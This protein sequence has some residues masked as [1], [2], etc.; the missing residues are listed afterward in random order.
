MTANGLPILWQL[1][2]SH[3]NEKARWALD[4][5]RIPH[6]RRALVPGLHLVVARSLTDGAIETTPVLTLDGRS[7]GDSTAIIAALEERWPQPPLYP[8]DPAERR[9]ALEL[10]EYFDEELGP[11][12]RRALYHELLT[13][14]ELV[15]P[16]MVRGQRRFIQLLFRLA[17][18]ILASG[19]PPALQRQRDRGARQP[20]AI[21]G[22]DGADRARARSQRLSGRRPVHRR[23]PDGRVAALPGGAS[24]RSSRIR[25]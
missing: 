6:V 16:L 5:K 13:R 9:R 1:E 4:F 19:D 22:R 3:Y 15:V 17:F 10:E 23:R 25:Q 21:G 2:M 7:I 8:A 24:R 20:R 14:P 18:P 11:H 12:L